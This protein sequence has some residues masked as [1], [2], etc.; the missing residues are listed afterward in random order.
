M[1]AHPALVLNADSRP[2]QLFP[3]LAAVVAGRDHGG[4][5]GSR[6]GCRR[7]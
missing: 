1:Q 7:V 5:Q 3:A 6:R 2:L 4:V